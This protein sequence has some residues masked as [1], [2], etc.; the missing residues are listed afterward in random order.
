MAEGRHLQGW[1]SPRPSSVLLI[2]CQEGVLAFSMEQP[3][4]GLEMLKERAKELKVCILLNTW[5]INGLSTAWSRLLSS[6]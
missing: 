4:E 1:P 6:C 3:S 2:P 5:I